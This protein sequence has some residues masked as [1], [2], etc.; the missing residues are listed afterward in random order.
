MK[1]ALLAVLASAIWSAL[2]LY[3]LALHFGLLTPAR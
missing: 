3:L 2:S 1:R